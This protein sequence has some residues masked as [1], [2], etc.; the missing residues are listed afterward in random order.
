MAS[1]TSPLRTSGIGRILMALVVANLATAGLGVRTAEAGGT[2]YPL[3]H[4]ASLVPQPRDMPT[5]SCY[6]REQGS[7]N[8][9]HC[10]HIVERRTTM[11]GDSSDIVDRSER[12]A[13]YG[14]AITLKNGQRL[15]GCRY[16]DLY[17]LTCDYVGTNHWIRETVD[18][19]RS[20]YLDA[21]KKSQVTVSCALQLARFWKGQFDWNRVV[22]NCSGIRF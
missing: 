3:R 8:Y 10:R 20:Y 9:Y 4:Y 1:I 13:T 16:S 22:T 6:K 21:L 12:D 7:V 19:H 2:T 17:N 5:N 18:G 15:E 14:S 11:P